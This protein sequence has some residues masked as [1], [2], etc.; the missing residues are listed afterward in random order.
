[1]ECERYQDCSWFQEKPST[2]DF[3]SK[4]SPAEL[5]TPEI[6]SNDFDFTMQFANRDTPPWGD[7]NH[8]ELFDDD[9]KMAWNDTVIGEKEKNINNPA[10]EYYYNL[11]YKTEDNSVIDNYVLRKTDSFEI[12]NI[13][14]MDPAEVLPISYRE[15]LNNYGLF[16]FDEVKSEV[17]EEAELYSPGSST[18]VVDSDDSDLLIGREETI[19]VEENTENIQEITDKLPA[20]IWQEEKQTEKSLK[21]EGIQPLMYNIEIPKGNVPVALPVTNS[22]TE[23]L[24]HIPVQVP[25]VVPKPELSLELPKATFEQTV[26]VN[27]PDLDFMDLVDFINNVSVKRWKFCIL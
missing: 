7:E 12:K 24:A 22:Y 15:K 20:K 3:M 6:E 2:V 4:P 18:Y 5:T 14:S 8:I 1:M 25:A 13:S 21:M 16:P 10:N 19:E 9:V 27:T 17:K 11:N 26:E 23:N